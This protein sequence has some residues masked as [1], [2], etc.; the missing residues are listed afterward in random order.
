MLAPL[1]R[2]Q[3]GGIRKVVYAASST[4]YGNDPVPQ[5]ELQL[6]DLQTPYASSK[7]M[8]EL[9]MKQVSVN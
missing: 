8:G 2:L 1:L 6:P 3:V 7:Y 4:A 9:L 5:N